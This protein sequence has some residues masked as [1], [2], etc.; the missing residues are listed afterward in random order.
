M[1]GTRSYTNEQIKF[2]LDAWIDGKKAPEIVQAYR[3]AFGDQRFGV[4]QVKYLKSAYG[5]DA[6]FGVPL[7]NRVV[8]PSSATGRAV[9]SARTLAGASLSQRGFGR[10]SMRPLLG[11]G[12]NQMLTSAQQPADFP[13]RLASEPTPASI[14]GYDFGGTFSGGPSASGFSAISATASSTSTAGTSTGASLRNISFGA[15]RTPYGPVAQGGIL[16]RDAIMPGLSSSGP[17]DASWSGPGQGPSISAQK[18]AAEMRALTAPVSGTDGTLPDAAIG[19]MTP[20]LPS[21]SSFPAETA[22]PSAS[23]LVMQA[24]KAPTGG[25]RSLLLP[26]APENSKAANGSPGDLAPFSP[27]AAAVGED[28]VGWH[29]TSHHGCPI[30]AKHRHDA[31]GGIHFGGMR[32]LRQA[33][34]AHTCSKLEEVSR[35][36]W[37]AISQGEQPQ[38]PEQ[39][40]QQGEDREQKEFARSEAPETPVAE[41]ES[42]AMEECDD[43]D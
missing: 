40:E 24:G 30:Q 4:S 33:M 35:A 23:A 26:T 21:L 9:Q 19:L 32:D 7:V 20:D 10:P 39:P 12:T 14:Q 22:G 28:M 37:G 43:D 6:E 3:Q 31:D 27:Q 5:E 11:T 8:R 34:A 38:Q 29:N 36:E 18:S 13:A 41:D 42:T 15:A 1:G 2:V 17:G 25:E 16:G